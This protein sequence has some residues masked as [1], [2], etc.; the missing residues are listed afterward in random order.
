MLS[1]PATGRG[2]LASGPVGLTRHILRRI[3]ITMIII[4]VLISIVILIV[5]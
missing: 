5:I 1:S 2:P 4:V 3:M